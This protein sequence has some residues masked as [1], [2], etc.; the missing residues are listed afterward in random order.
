MLN[1]DLIEA[2]EVGKLQLSELKDIRAEAYE[3][4]RPY[5]ERV[6][7]FH[8]K[9]ILRKEFTL[10]MKEL[11]YDY[12]LYLFREIEV[13]MEGFIYCFHKFFPMVQLKS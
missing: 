4:A 2:G 5:K 11:L 9:H 8:D 13:S 6:K 1:L 7:L 10:G 12:K 3:N